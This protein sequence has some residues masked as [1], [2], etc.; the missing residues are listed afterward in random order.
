MLQQMGANYPELLARYAKRTDNPSGPGVPG[1]LARQVAAAIAAVPQLAEILSGSAAAPVLTGSITV[2]DELS[3]NTAYVTIYQQ[4]GKT[5]FSR[6]T[7]INWACAGLAHVDTVFGCHHEGSVYL[8][9]NDA[10]LSDGVHEVMHLLSWLRTRSAWLTAFGH[11]LEEAAAEKISQIVCRAA[12]I[13]Q[14][15]DIYSAHVAILE[16][17][18]NHGGL[19]DRDVCKAYFE[20][21]V[22]PVRTAILKVAGK[23]GL[24]ILL[25]YKGG[26]ILQTTGPWI[27]AFRKQ[28]QENSGTCLVQ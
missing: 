28:Q 12:R 22:E 24:Q 21:D 20:G 3:F 14:R 1:D 10:Q 13:P 23:T 25:D 27:A 16:M 19:S 15:P 6:F 26:D 2:L 18:M 4:R 11:L 5:T 8:R 7:G 17:I 9:D